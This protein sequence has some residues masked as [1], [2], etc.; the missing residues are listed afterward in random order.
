MNA[1][2]EHPAPRR[3]SDIAGS[4]R[5]RLEAISDGLFAVGMTLLVLGLAVPMVK[6]VSSESDLWRAL[7]NLFPS[8]VTYFMSFLT[9]G[10]FWV[11]QQAQLTKVERPNR[12]FTWMHLIFLMAVT[13]VPFSTQLLARFHWSRLALIVY[14]LNI[15]VMGVMLLVSLEYGLR[16]NVFPEDHRRTVALFFRR[17]I[18]G[19]QSLYLVAMLLSFVDT[20]LSIAAFVAIQLNFVIAPPIPFLRDI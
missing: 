7:G 6:D 11:G 2:T 9:L 13:L 18:I 14:W 15:A 5:A 3:F 1:G 12:G 20:H 4:N 17:R 16:T 19:A 10:I 8:V